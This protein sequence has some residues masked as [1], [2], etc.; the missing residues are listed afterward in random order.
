MNKSFK[1]IVGHLWAVEPPGH[2]LS[3][4][5]LHNCTLL[6]HYADS[7]QVNSVIEYICLKLKACLCK[8]VL[9]INFMELLSRVHMRKIN[10]GLRSV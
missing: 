9:S 5:Q 8:H 7:Y 1:I 2:V 4:L 3:A 10:C 6:K